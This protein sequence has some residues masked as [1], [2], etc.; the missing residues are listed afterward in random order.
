MNG[1]QRGREQPGSAPTYFTLKSCSKIPRRDGF[2]RDGSGGRVRLVRTRCSQ[3][4]RTAQLLCGPR[5][6]CG[7]PARVVN[8]L[9][10]ERCAGSFSACNLRAAAQ[11]RPCS[12]Q[13]SPHRPLT[14]ANSPR[15]GFANARL[16]RSRSQ[17]CPAIRGPWHLSLLSGAAVLC[18][19]PGF[20]PRAPGA[21]R[22]GMEG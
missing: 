13:R 10:G 6:P 15:D 19:R 7:T 18:S 17:A 4:V 16:P 21:R 9:R 11:I 14:R 1:R 20:S 3:D 5:R 2:D 22:P 12:A 8:Q